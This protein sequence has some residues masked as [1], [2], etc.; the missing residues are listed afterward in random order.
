MLPRQKQRS[1]G[2]VYITESL[3]ATEQWPG[4][5]LE[6]DILT[7]TLVLTTSNGY[8][9]KSGNGQFEQFIYSHIFIPSSI[10]QSSRK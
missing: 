10:I 9:E 6:A 4:Q 8:L 1:T 2:A 5:G 7:Y 3:L